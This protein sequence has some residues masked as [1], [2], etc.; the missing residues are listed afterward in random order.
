MNDCYAY[1]DESD[2]VLKF[3]TPLDHL[4]CIECLD[5]KTDLMDSLLF[6]SLSTLSDSL[7]YDSLQTLGYT[8]F[9]VYIEFTNNYSTSTKLDGYISAI[10]DWMA[11]GDTSASPSTTHFDPALLSTINTDGAYAIGDTFYV[12]TDSNEVYEI[13][14]ND[15]A[16]LDSFLIGDATVAH[17]KVNKKFSLWEECRI[18]GRERDQDNNENLFMG[19]I[20]G[21]YNVPF[22]SRF[23]AKTGSFK[24]VY[25][26]N[27]PQI[28]RWPNKNLRATIGGAAN[29]V[30][31]DEYTN[32]L[33][34]I[35][36]KTRIY[37]FHAISI[38]ARKRFWQVG[39][40]RAK[41]GMIES[42]HGMNGLSDLKQ[43]I[44]W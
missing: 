7:I 13:K 8:P 28:I 5:A 34:T 37:S 21:F 27:L 16:L 39:A 10:E 19:T 25:N 3:S 14:S 17:R 2:G 42:I 15:V 29:E 43:E 23:K 33:I 1:A 20:T 12:I 44:T 40:L 32:R 36:I 4:N 41:S 6:S 30:K 24:L 26:S 31:N 18:F 35:P 11:E 22:F 38:H 9:D